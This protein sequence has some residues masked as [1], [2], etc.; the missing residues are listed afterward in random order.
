MPIKSTQE[1]LE[2]LDEIR[3]F[4]I[5]IDK[6]QIEVSDTD[7]FEEIAKLLKTNKWPQAVPGNLLVDMNS[8]Q[9]KMDRAEGICDLMI[10]IPLENKKILDFGCGEGHLVHYSKNEMNTSKSIGY[11]IHK[12]GNLKWEEDNIL[13]TNDFSKVIKNGPYD[14]IILYD[15][16]DHLENETA[17]EVFDKIK[18]VS[19][20]ETQI[21]IRCH[22]WCCRHG[23]HHYSSMNKAFIHVVF[24][25]EELEMLNIKPSIN[26]TKRIY[27]PIGHYRKI[28]NDNGLKLIEE[29]VS[30]KN[31]EPFFEMPMIKHRIRKHW[32]GSGDKK[33]RNW[34]RHQLEQSTIDYILTL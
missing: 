23:S 25:E 28:W 7:N 6:Q 19:T 4:I 24:S 8:E 9:S 34:P 29:D 21:Y 17:E 3:D 10:E 15:V 20:S 1:V 26:Y 14:A 33:A 32:A 27:H 11:D 30:K 18:Q 31:V 12:S 22:P 16:I 5:S 13:L 2:K